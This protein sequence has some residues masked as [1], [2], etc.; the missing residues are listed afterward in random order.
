MHTR[1]RPAVAT[2]PDLLDLLVRFPPRR[3]DRGETVILN[4]RHQDP[5]GPGSLAYVVEG[6]V[7]GAWYGPFIAPDHRAT[8]IVAGDGRWVGADAFKYG[9]NLYR[10]DALT[11]TLAAIVPLDYLENEAPRTTLLDALRCVSVDW[12]TAA[13]VLGLGSHTLRRRTLLLLYN[14]ARLHPRP[15]IEVRQQDVAELL[16]VAR[17]SLQPVLKRLEREGLVTTGYGEIVVGDSEALLA[18]LREPS[19]RVRTRAAPRPNG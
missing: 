19:Q 8:T 13:S 10:Y 2:S 9:A 14:L 6:L 15:E 12:C 5:P 11:P 3:F 16:G 18:K 4:T 7:R 17:Q 1:H